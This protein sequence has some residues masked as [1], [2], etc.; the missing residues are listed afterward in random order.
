MKIAS[1]LILS[2]LFC[3][4]LNA[5]GEYRVFTDIQK[6]TVS[7]KLLA[8]KSDRICI[9]L[10][11]GRQIEILYSH[12]SIEDRNFLK[13][14]NDSNKI[15]K[16][17]DFVLRCYPGKYLFITEYNEDLAGR[18]SHFDY[19]S[20]IPAAKVLTKGSPAVIAMPKAENLQR[21][22]WFKDYLMRYDA[23]KTYL[24]GSAMTAENSECIDGDSSDSRARKLATII[25]KR[26]HYAVIVPED[27]YTLAL[28]GSALASLLNGPLLYA[29]GRNA[30]DLMK[31]LD[32]LSVNS[33][34]TLGQLDKNMGFETT[35]LKDSLAIQKWVKS[36][37]I[38][39]PDYLAVTNPKD[40]TL[41]DGP[42]LS[43]GA[44][45]IAAKNNG[46][47]YTI[48]DASRVDVVLDELSELYAALGS[49]PEYLAIVGSS[50]AMPQTVLQDK[51]MIG[52]TIETDRYYANVD[53]DEFPDIAV[54]RLVANN[55]SELSLIMS[56]IA[57][58]SKLREKKWQNK[59]VQTG[60]WHWTEITPLLDNFGIIE[61]ESLL[62]EHAG[63]ENY[64]NAF[65]TLHSAH[66]NSKYLGGAFHLDAQ[67]LLSPT[68]IFSQGCSV[69]GICQ[70]QQ[71]HRYI[72]KELFKLGAVAFFGTGR[73]GTAE[74]SQVY[75]HTLNKILEGASLGLAHKDSLACKLVYAWDDPQNK[76]HLR[77]YF[78]SAFF[79]DPA[80][81]V[82]VDSAPRVPPAK[83]FYANDVY[84][85][86]VPKEVFS[87]PLNKALMDEWKWPGETL[88]T[89]SIPGITDCRMWQGDYDE[90]RHIYHAKVNSDQ[91]IKSVR[92]IKR[93]RTPLGMMGKVYEDKNQD[94][95]ILSRWN[96]Q[97]MDFDN[98]KNRVVNKINEIKFEIT[99]K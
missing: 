14:L 32:E 37:L 22:P 58:W 91:G 77:A 34:I 23:E 10:K 64:I 59:Y 68:V 9:Q 30:V 76:N 86:T 13:I 5:A 11:D 26:S 70:D 42:N 61:G 72:S 67:S 20:A 44:P 2:L 43:L 31:V 46:L 41:E 85:L 87:L 55:G 27:D 50:T 73:P 57:T 25:W 75:T 62:H 6:R 83:S 1:F 17:D 89:A 16:V 93:P 79:G 8:I 99:H 95:S 88:Y 98:E 3:N 92:Q 94:G 51:M 80:M 54:G 33:V 84:K 60:H 47:V 63:K 56:R 48:K 96:I 38:E 82:E 36:N 35:A 97:V 90:H 78:N 29:N 69:A 21:I 49:Y 53:E 74:T 39:S 24:M 7:A 40:C 28:E 71:S 81:V 66:S 19:L 12:L 65:F 18:S 52:K 15:E 4:L 45:L